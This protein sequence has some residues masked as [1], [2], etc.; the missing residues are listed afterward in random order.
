MHS[1]SNFQIVGNTNIPGSGKQ[2]LHT[3]GGWDI[4]SA[5]EAEAAAEPWPQ[6][7]ASL[8]F[9]F[10]TEA[11]G[12]SNGPTELWPGTHM[13]PQFANDAIAQRVE[14]TASQQ[15]EAMRRAVSPPVLNLL[16][17]GAVSV[18]DYRLWH[19]GLPNLGDRPR[20][21]IAL[22]Y[23]RRT[24]Y[25]E[26]RP[27]VKTHAGGGLGG[28]FRFAADCADAFSRRWWPTPALER[29][30]RQEQQGIHFNWNVEFAAPGVIVDHFG[31]INGDL[32]GNDR[33]NYWFPH[34]PI[35]MTRATDMHPWVT[36]T[37]ARSQHR[38]H[39]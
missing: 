38:S 34:G 14:G 36:L 18:R 28:R 15:R 6:P 20:H 8:V 9:N 25:N 1:D 37:A 16:P 24:N 3:D 33:G 5:E 21:M 12:V 32:S 22:S 10:S 35:D 23:M 29:H 11:I 30:R 19:R 17:R 4:R 7:T 13:D 2:L 39:L 31:N 27:G 26:A